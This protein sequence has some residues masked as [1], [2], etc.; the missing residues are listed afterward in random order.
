AASLS[1]VGAATGPP[2]VDGFPNPASSINTSRMFGASRGALTGCVNDATDPSSVRFVTPSNGCGGR[3][4]TVRSHSVSKAATD[5][6]RAV[7]ASAIALKN[8][9][10][11]RILIPSRNPRGYTRRFESTRQKRGANHEVL[12]HVEAVA[13]ATVK[14]PLHSCISTT[15]PDRKSTRL[16]SSHRTIS[17]AVFCLKKKKKHKNNRQ[18]ARSTPHA[19]PQFVQ[20]ALSL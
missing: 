10:H 2:N 3:G 8:M 11:F 4:R 16:N 20:G 14:A 12:E 13:L 19:Y 7:T 15:A 1:N 6:D 17:Y 18:N 9:I 5:I